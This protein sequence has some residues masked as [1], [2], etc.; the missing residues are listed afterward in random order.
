VQDKADLLGRMTDRLLGEV[1]TPAGVQ[2]GDW[3]VDLRQLLRSFV[4]VRQRH[5]CTADL[6]QR[7]PFRSAEA[8]RLTELALR[9]LHGA[10]LELSEALQVVQQLGTLLLVRPA[11]ASLVSPDPDP[12]AAAELKRRYPLLA[13]LGKRGWR[14]N[15]PDQDRD[16]G[17]ELLILGIEGLLR[18]RRR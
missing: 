5:P 2:P 18:R 4:L 7:Q 13:S 14:W 17:V 3:R 12:G 11:P 15:Q 8:P 16:L 6:L 9:I 10:G 1:E